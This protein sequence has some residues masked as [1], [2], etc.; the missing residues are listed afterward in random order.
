MMDKAYIVGA[1]EHPLRKAPNKTIAQ[2]HCEA[3]MGALADCGLD[4]DDVDGYF[5]AGDTPGLGAI[6][7]ADYLSISP[8][9]CDTTESGGVSYMLHVARAVRAVVAGKCDVALI[10]LAGR[11]RSAPA[12]VPRC[13]APEL[14]FESLYGSSAVNFNA[15]CAMRHMYEFGTTSEQLAWI[16]VAASQHAQHNPDAMLSKPVTI[17]EVLASPL[18]ATPLHQ[19]DCCVAT[20]GAEALVIVR[21]EIAKKLKR[22]LIRVRGSGEGLKGQA[23]GAV[24]LTQSAASISGPAAFEAAGVKPDDIKY[25]SVD[26][27]FTIA[28]LIQLEDLGF[29]EKGQGGKFVADGNLISGEG[30]LPFNTDGGGLCNSH[31]DNHGG[32]VIEA[33][34]Q[35][36]GEAHE[37]VQVSNCDLALASGVDGLLGHR[38]ASA[39][40]IMER[41]A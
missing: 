40:L 23:G 26:D 24:N 18:I 38:H 28:A 7:M 1:F 31:P 27:S 17:E 19:L 25:V 34:R 22:P 33:V 21:L 9:Y 14:N 4:L 12:P 35:L 39:T 32:M 16:R 41:I 15:M 37:A 3:A 8:R 36:R 5:C 13:S 20:D 30:R 2:L 10:T 11:S 6:S 29:C